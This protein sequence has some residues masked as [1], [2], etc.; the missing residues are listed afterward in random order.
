MPVKVWRHE[1]L[2]EWAR[3][4]NMKH[5]YQSKHN[6]IWS[7]AHINSKKEKKHTR[8]GRKC[9]CVLCDTN[10]VYYTVITNEMSHIKHV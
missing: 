4:Y 6:V 10:F 1:F 7:Q 2:S 8:R 5:L 9:N 3:Q